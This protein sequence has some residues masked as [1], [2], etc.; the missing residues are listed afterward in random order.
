MHLKYLLALNAFHFTSGPFRI[1]WVRFGYDPRKDPS[2]RKYQIIDYRLR[3]KFITFSGLEYWK[4]FMKYFWSN[5]LIVS[6]IIWLKDTCPVLYP[7]FHYDHPAIR[8]IF[9]IIAGNYLALSNFFWLS[10]YVL[11]VMRD[12]LPE[13]FG[14]GRVKNLKNENCEKLFDP[15]DES[16]YKFKP[17]VIPPQ[18]QVFYQV[19]SCFILSNNL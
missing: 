7:L 2:A 4:K 9:N 15:F 6:N 10:D 1:A 12:R 8:N 13:K 17:G 18:K 5:Y 11:N 16:L 14:R 19:N 3:S